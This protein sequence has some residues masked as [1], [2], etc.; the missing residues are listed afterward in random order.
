MIKKIIRYLRKRK[1]MKLRKWCI[2]LAANELSRGEA[3]DAANE[4]SGLKSSLNQSLNF[5]VRFLSVNK[6]VPLG[7]RRCECNARTAVFYSVQTTDSVNIHKKFA[8]FC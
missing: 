3:I 8:I 5:F 2:T 7:R 6:D 4:T 1:D